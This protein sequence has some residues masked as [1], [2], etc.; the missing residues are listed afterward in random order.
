M[1]TQFTPPP[2]ERQITEKQLIRGVFT[3]F[4]FLCFFL[5]F[6]VSSFG[7]NVDSLKKVANSNSVSKPEKLN[8]LSKLSQYLISNATTEE[9]IP[10]TKKTRLLAI[11]LKNKTEKTTAN[12]ILSDAYLREQ[13]FSLAKKYAEETLTDNEEDVKKYLLGINALGRVY[14]HFQ[15]YQKA[16]EVYNTG[17]TRYKEKPKRT[18][19]IAQIYLNLGTSYER[20]ELNDKVFDCYLKALHYSDSIGSSRLRYRTLHCLGTFHKDLE[21]YSEAEKYLL[22]GL[23]DINN[24]PDSSFILSANNHALGILYSRWGKYEKA[25]K[26][27]TI[28]LRAFKKTGKKLYV[29]D[30]LNNMAVLYYKMDS[31]QKSIDYGKSALKLAKEL[32]HTLA[33]NGAKQTIACSYLKLGDLKTAE[34]YYKQIIPNMDNRAI[35][36]LKSKM[37]LLQN[38]SDLYEKKG[39]YPLALKY[40][41]EMKIASDTLIKREK[42]QHVT[43][44]EQKY[45]SE[46]KEKELEQERN[47][48]LSKDIEIKKKKAQNAW[49]FFGLLLSVG[50]VA[51]LF[52]L[53]NRRKKRL[54]LEKEK[55]QKK[56]TE[57]QD[58]KVRLNKTSLLAKTSQEELAQEKQKNA[59]NSTEK[60]PSLEIFHQQLQKEIQLSDPLFEFWLLQVEGL[61]VKEIAKRVHR[62]TEGVR[63]RSKE[64]YKILR[65]VNDLPYDA[66]FTRSKSI[67]TYREKLRIYTESAETPKKGGK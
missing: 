30:V 47:K 64:L 10:W 31:L 53:L 59:V 40:H 11:Q 42:F 17:I 16:I 23:T 4:V 21:Q 25:I 48:V 49:L 22:E 24:N 41:K 18:T 26:A 51:L 35:F 2:Y 55:I 1:N 5:I 66:P 3:S 58:L 19:L 50:L 28:A 9:T 67:K 8:A 32:K 45:Q 13:N 44:L 27:N 37:G 60:T 43:K 46:K 7:Q 65:E 61:T 39:N 14:H 36:S 33:I 34:N 12:L 20:L 63:S 62:S 38:L 6:S 15:K 56:I 52:F 54:I 57:I 29:F